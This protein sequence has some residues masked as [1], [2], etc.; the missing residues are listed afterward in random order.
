M[1]AM[2]WAFMDLGDNMATA[3]GKVEAINRAKCVGCVAGHHVHGSIDP[4]WY[5]QHFCSA[6]A[7]PILNRGVLYASVN[8]GDVVILPRPAAPM[9]SMIVARKSSFL[10]HTYVYV[11]G[12]N[13]TNTLGTGAFLQYDNADRDI[14]KAVYW[15]AQGAGEVFGLSVATGGRLY[16][17]PYLNYS[18][19]A[20]TARA[21]CA[22]AA[23]AWNYIGP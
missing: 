6:G 1:A 22:F 16:K 8:V 20:A 7:V 17:I 11:R 15:H 4:N 13:N 18:A 23:G 14:D 12:F 3:Q 10:G 2:H 5:G 19:S 21:N 9:H